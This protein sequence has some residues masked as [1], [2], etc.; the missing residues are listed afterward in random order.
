M[1]PESASGAALLLKVLATATP[2]VTPKLHIKA[3]M[4]VMAVPL[5]V[6]GARRTESNGSIGT[7]SQV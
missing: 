2:Q 3:H 4:R 6:C 5:S 7:L 1:P